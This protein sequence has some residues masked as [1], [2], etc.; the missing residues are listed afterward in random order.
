[1]RL[2]S[3]FTDARVYIGTVV[4]FGGASFCTIQDTTDWYTET[5]HSTKNDGAIIEGICDSLYVVL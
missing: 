1:M 4:Y 2:W 5:A 3:V